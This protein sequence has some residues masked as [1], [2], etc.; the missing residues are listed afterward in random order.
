MGAQQSVGIESN[1]TGFDFEPVTANTEDLRVIFCFIQKFEK[2]V[3]VGTYARLAT[4]R[5]QILPEVE[6]TIKQFKS[7]S[8]NSFFKL[9]NFWLKQWK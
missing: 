8:S 1:K 7:S 2:D 6:D 3:P 5:P 4:Q 9:R